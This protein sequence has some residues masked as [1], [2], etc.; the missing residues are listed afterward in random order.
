[1]KPFKPTNHQREVQRCLS[2][3]KVTEPINLEANRATG[4]VNVASFEIYERGKTEGEQTLAMEIIGKRGTLSDFEQALRDKRTQLTEEA[5]KA[6]TETERDAN[7]K[8]RFSLSDMI[9][10]QLNPGR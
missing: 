4:E 1:M 7:L 2:N 10:Q 8:N 3:W 5:S 9:F 6:E